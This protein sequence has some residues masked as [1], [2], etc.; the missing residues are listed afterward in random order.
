MEGFV[1]QATGMAE[2]DWN[3]RTGSPPA[4]EVAGAI[5]VTSLYPFGLQVG[6]GG[7]TY[8]VPRISG[9]NIKLLCGFRIE[10]T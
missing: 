9:I 3:L 2:R 5:V 1:I 10:L 8:L 6:P 4:L 7:L